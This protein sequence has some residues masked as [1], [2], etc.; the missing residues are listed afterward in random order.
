MNSK[1]LLKK[2][3]SVKNSF[4]GKDFGLTKKEIKALNNEMKMPWVRPGWD[5]IVCKQ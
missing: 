1:F 3:F 4:L 5:K 2:L